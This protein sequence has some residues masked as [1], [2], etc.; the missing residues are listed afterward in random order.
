MVLEE[1]PYL[2]WGDAGERVLGQLVLIEET[3]AVRLDVR[4]DGFSEYL[5]Q[6]DELVDVIGEGVC[7]WRSRS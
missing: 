2:G 3:H 6:K 5:A 1:A 7:P 4:G